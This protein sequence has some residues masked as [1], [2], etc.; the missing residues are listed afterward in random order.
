MFV[1]S[2]S[3][4]K[5]V[6]GLREIFNSLAKIRETLLTINVS[7]GYV[8]DTSVFNKIIY[9][10]VSDVVRLLISQKEYDKLNNYFKTSCYKWMINIIMLNMYTVANKCL[11]HISFINPTS[12]NSSQLQDYYELSSRF[13]VLTNWCHSML[14][15]SIKQHLVKRNVNVYS[16]IISGFDTEFVALDW[17]KNELLSAQLSSTHVL[18]LSIPLYKGFDFEGVNTLTS[19]TYLKALPKFQEID[20]IKSFISDKIKECRFYKFRDHDTYMNKLANFFI[21]N[22]RIDNI[23]L[24]SRN[25]IV[26]FKKLRIKNLFVLPVEGEK[27]Q[28]NFSTLVH[29]ITSQVDRKSIEDRLIQYIM[30]IDFSALPGFVQDC[31]DIVKESWT[32]DTLIKSGVKTIF[33]SNE[34]NSKLNS[35]STSSSSNFVVSLGIDLGKN[36]SETSSTYSNSLSNI[37]KGE[38]GGEET[39]QETPNLLLNRDSDL[40]LKRININF[41]RK[42]YLAAHYNAADL[43]LLEDWKSVSFRNVDI[44]K[45]CFTSLSLP[46]KYN[47]KEKVYLRDT[48]LLSSAAASSL[49]AVA[50]AYGLEK[51]ELAQF[52]K[53]N[54]DVLL[55]D[56]LELFREY[57]M[58]DS[59]ITLIHILFINDF[60][61]KLG[62]LTVPNTLGT[63]SSRYVKNK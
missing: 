34:E 32:K 29:L 22:D 58:N 1:F 38:L 8:K 17:G 37:T 35:S 31:E 56:N 43:T 18:K 63:L 16:E 2:D 52:Y 9:P 25:L 30:N 55:K 40:K 6:S 60:S 42:I 24:T 12:L 45:K 21:N 39:K 13:E 5:N 28:I 23:A 49:M 54:M 10:I 27:L 48:L 7:N 50:K 46:M 33:L 61:F 20:L 15:N 4:F 47:G 53:E 14:D 59:L 44:V 62:G 26:M 11:F 57:A 36:S 19:E 41:R 51:I 3:L